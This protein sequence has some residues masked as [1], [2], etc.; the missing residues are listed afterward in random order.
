MS[1]RKLGRVEE[2]TF[3]RLVAQRAE[4]RARGSPELSLGCFGCELRLRQCVRCLLAPFAEVI[5]SAGWAAPA[6]SDSAAFCGL[7]S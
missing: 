1:C 7:V 6:I 4:G 5:G 2:S 3:R